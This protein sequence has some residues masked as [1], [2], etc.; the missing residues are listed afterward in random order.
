MR[1]AVILLAVFGFAAAAVRMVRAALWALHGGVEG[2]LARDAAATRARRGDL[3]GL[4]DA[5]AQRALARRRR[6]LA[7][8][9]AS[10]WAGLLLVPPLTPWPTALYASYSLLWLLPRRS[11]LRP[12]Q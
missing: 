9:A 1:T 10:L 2:F 12:P 5:E 3:T 7:L 6:M 4:A 11:S 8:G